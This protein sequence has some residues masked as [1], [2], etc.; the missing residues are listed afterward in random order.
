MSY[1]MPGQPVP[2]APKVR[3]T[4][5]TAAT[6]LLLVAAAAYVFLAVLGLSQAGTFAEIFEEAY[7]GTELEGTGEVLG[8]V[9]A[10]V[11]GVFY[12]LFAVGFAV[13]ALLDYR[14]KNPARIVTWVIGGIA[15]C[16]TGVSLV[17]AGVDTAMG[18]DI[19]GPD[20][21]ELERMLEEALP[22][23]YYPVTWAT[24]GL[25]VVA[26]LTALILLAMP[27]ANDFFRKPRPGVAP[28][29]PPPYPQT[30]L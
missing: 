30:G 8:L 23:W 21:A 19:N 7:A 14:G 15:L 20:A 18:T 10:I 24:T 25:T 1:A 27:S 2:E 12:L 29:P 11:T 28:P 16:C 9:T 13:L 6:W 5:V 3:P 4:T 22:A 17:F 26:L